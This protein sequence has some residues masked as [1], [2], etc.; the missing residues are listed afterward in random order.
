MAEIEI[1]QFLKIISG[2]IFNSHKKLEKQITDINEIVANN[3]TEGEQLKAAN[4]ELNQKMK[5]QNAR[6]KNLEENDAKMKSII[7][8]QQ[9]MLMQQD[10]LVCMKRLIFSG[11]PENEEWKV[12]DNTVYTKK[13]KLE[14]ILKHLEKS[15]I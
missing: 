14:L 13:Q 1:G 7:T 4:N 2:T 9:S 3:V 12:Q 6:I 5:L 11:I 10:R 8:K 15:E